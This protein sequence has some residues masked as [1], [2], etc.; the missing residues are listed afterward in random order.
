MF[1]QGGSGV[2]RILNAAIDLFGRHGVRGTSLRAIAE[3]ADVSAALIV[4]HYGSKAGLHD[5]CDERV[6]AF[7]AEVKRDSVRTGFSLPLGG[8]QAS[9]EHSRPALRYVARNL[10]DGGP[11]IG[12][13]IDEMVRDAIGYTAEAQEAGLVRPSE[14]PEARVAVLTVWMLGG[15]ALHEHI[16]RL[17]GAD[18]LGEHGDARRYMEAA[19]DIIRPGMLTDLAM[20]NIETGPEAEQE[21]GPESE[22]ETK[23]EIDDE[24]DVS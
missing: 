3:A 15:L 4:H 14:D 10:I 16:H 21:T 7:I 19:V 22:E 11:R 24:E 1:S 6:L 9:V 23:T 17:I 2:D 8:L 13:F 5:A 12:D 20:A 18:L